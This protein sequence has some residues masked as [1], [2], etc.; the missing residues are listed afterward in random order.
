VATTIVFCALVALCEGIDLQ[1]AGVAASGIAAEF[2]P[3]PGEM[4]TFFSGSTLG[5]FVGALIGGIT[6]NDVQ[7][8]IAQKGTLGYWIGQPYAGQG[9]MAEAVDLVCDFAF[10]TLRLHRVEASCLPNNEPSKKLLARTGFE[11]EGYAKAYL[12]ING[13]W[14]DHILWGKT[15]KEKV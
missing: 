15:M 8:G 12:Q 5:L 2:K 9:Y 11:Q 3:S 14:Q 1:A 4:G 7:T 6:L 13:T 10:R